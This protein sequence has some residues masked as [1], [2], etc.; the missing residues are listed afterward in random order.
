MLTETMCIYAV[1]DDNEEIGFKFRL[2]PKRR[3]WWMNDND[4]CV[5]ETE[6]SYS[7]PSN[8][9]KEQLVM[10]AIETLKDKQK[11]TMANAQLKYNSL[12][13]KINKFQL[14]THQPTETEIDGEVEVILK[15]PD[16]DIPF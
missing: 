7:P 16:D 10:K 4:I 8:M 9:T 5:G 15:N 11:E 13:A 14:L 2:I 1:P 3:K 6:V 12:Q